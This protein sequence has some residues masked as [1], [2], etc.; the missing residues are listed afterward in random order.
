MVYR[1]WSDQQKSLGCYTG[2]EVGVGMGKPLTYLKIVSSVGN[3]SLSPLNLFTLSKSLVLEF[4]NV[5]R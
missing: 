3:V 1:V 2:E 4:L 5:F